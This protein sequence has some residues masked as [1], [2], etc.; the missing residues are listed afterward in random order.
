MPRGPQVRQSRLTRLAKRLGLAVAVILICLLGVGFWLAL[1]QNW[2]M[3]QAVAALRQ[4]G[5]P[6]Q[7]SDLGKHDVPDADNAALVYEQAF[8]ALRLTH[9]DDLFLTQLVKDEPARASAAN[10]QRAESILEANQGALQLLEQA[11]KMP[12]SRFPVNWEAYPDQKLGHLSNLRKSARLLSAHVWLS[13]RKGNAEEALRRCATIF[14]L[15]QSLAEEPTMVSQLPRYSIIAIAYTALQSALED[16]R[17]PPEQCLALAEQLA[18]ID[19]NQGYITA[20]QGERAMGLAL[21]HMMFTGQGLAKPGSDEQSRQAV[22]SASDKS[23]PRELPGLTPLRLLFA[24]DV[25]RFLKNMERLIEVARLP[26]RELVKVKS[27]P[28][29]EEPS[30]FPPRLLSGVLMPVFSGSRTVAYRDA[31]SAPLRLAQVALRLKAYRA[32]HTEY[33]DSLATLEQAAAKPLPQDPFAGKP[34]GYRREGRGFLLYSWGPNLKDDGG[35]PPP[36]R[37]YTQGDILFQCS[38]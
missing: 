32:A 14:A 15:N 6:T 28:R 4:S 17:P 13:V 27:L 34:F 38:R 5:A 24:G 18:H 2:K 1:W 35:T 19:L 7:L 20:L 36:K 22:Q 11:S 9:D 3:D 30:L 29:E 23:A 8:K 10:V 12:R 21:V 16:S 25:L 33:P 26:Y 37:Q 31:A